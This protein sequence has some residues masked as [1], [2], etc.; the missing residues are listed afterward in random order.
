[1]ARKTHQPLVL[2]PTAEEQL[3]LDR[4]I[5]WQIAHEQ[6]R[7]RNGRAYLGHRIHGASKTKQG[8]NRAACRGQVSY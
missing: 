7:T 6:G 4:H 2:A 1:M 3:A 8:R 5:E